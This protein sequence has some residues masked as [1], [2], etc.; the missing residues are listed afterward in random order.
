[1]VVRI[2]VRKEAISFGGLI[3]NFLWTRKSRVQPCASGLWSPH[4]IRNSITAILCLRFRAV[5]QLRSNE[6]RNAGN[7]FSMDL[8]MLHSFIAYH[9]ARA[10]SFTCTPLR[11][12]DTC[13]GTHT[14]GNCVKRRLCAYRWR[15]T[16]RSF[17]RRSRRRQRRQ[18]Q[19]RSMMKS[20]LSVEETREGDLPFVKAGQMMRALV[21]SRHRLL[22]VPPEITGKMSSPAL[23]VQSSECLSRFQCSVSGLD[24]MHVQCLFGL[25]RSSAVLVRATHVR[26]T[27]RRRVSSEQRK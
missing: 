7:L 3:T 12:L 19:M 17:L 23:A 13:S 10:A 4:R 21:R 20:S 18:M 16:L 1:M 25:Y 8:I 9:R 15:R 5:L 14:V 26:V 11:I 22:V 27:I 24:S 2:I 6:R